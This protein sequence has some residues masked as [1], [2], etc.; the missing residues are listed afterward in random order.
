M[1]ELKPA[2][3]AAADALRA[4]DP[5]LASGLRVS[6][7]HLS[8]AAPD[9]A[10]AAA[11]RDE[12][13]ALLDH[14]AD[15]GIGGRAEVS[16]TLG[17]LGR[18]LG[19][20]GEELALEHA[21]A[22]CA[23]A[24]RAGT[25]ATLDMQDHRSTDAVLTAV[26]ELRADHPWVGLA[27]QAALR[28]TEADCREL[29]HAG[30][31]VRLVKGAYREPPAIAFTARGETDRSYVRCLRLLMEGRGYP[32]VATHDERLIE[33]AGFLAV[34]TERPQGTYEFQFRYGVR[35]DLQRRLARA[36]ETVRVWIPYGA[37]RPSD[38]RPARWRGV[39]GWRTNRQ[40]DTR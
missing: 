37:A 18:F 11:A 19:P 34:R 22:I 29:L 6:F 24:E 7:D 21:R 35:P 31:R 32:M 27:V 30:S 10:G 3:R 8:G 2:G 14:S 17:A 36:G 40:W 25:V 9:R 5:L 28:R 20:E 4:A 23:A 33:I 39:R 26:A 16:F 12:Y 1:A 15:Q 13:L 38:S